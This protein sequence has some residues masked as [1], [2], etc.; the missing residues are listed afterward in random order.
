MIKQ[1]AKLM[2]LSW[3]PFMFLSGLAADQA[4]GVKATIGFAYAF[5]LN[6]FVILNVY[7]VL[8]VHGLLMWLKVIVLLLVQCPVPRDP[9]MRRGKP[10]LT[11]CCEGLNTVCTYFHHPRMWIKG[12]ICVGHALFVCWQGCK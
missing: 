9:T 5:I 8:A 1:L 6:L 11:T 2:A 4:A 12:S 3:N 7:T 10:H